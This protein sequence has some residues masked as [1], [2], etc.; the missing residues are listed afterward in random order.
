MHEKFTKDTKMCDLAFARENTR[1]R[2][3]RLLKESYDNGKLAILQLQIM[4]KYR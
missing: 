2:E 3:K 1:I 4:A